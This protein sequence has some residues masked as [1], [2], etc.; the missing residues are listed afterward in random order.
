MEKADDL[1]GIA[2]QLPLKFR[3]IFKNGENVENGEKIIA[4]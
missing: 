1:T 4:A 3:E 2:Y